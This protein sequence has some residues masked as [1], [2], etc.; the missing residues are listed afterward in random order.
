MKMQIY[1]IFDT[2]TAAYMQPFF[3]HS[4]G[5]ALRSF[6]DLVNDGKSQVAKHP[7]CYTLVRIGSFN[8]AKG[9]IIGEMVESLSTGL[10]ILAQNQGKNTSNLELKLE[11]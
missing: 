11:D 7:E 4:D 5:Q 1:S 9:E 10:E 3:Q 2:A 6:T 8:D